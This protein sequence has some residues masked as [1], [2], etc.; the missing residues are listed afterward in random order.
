M[1]KLLTGSFRSL[2]EPIDAPGDLTI[3]NCPRLVRIAG[4]IRIQGNLTIRGCPRLETLP[5]DLEVPGTLNIRG[6]ARLSHVPQTVR[7]GEDLKI[8]GRTRLQELP[9]LSVG[10][11]VILKRSV[12]SL[13]AG[14]RVAGTLALAS[15]KLK[16]T[17]A[18]LHVGG[19]LLIRRCPELTEI[20][21]GLHVGGGLELCFSEVES[22]PEVSVKH[23]VDLEGCAQLRELPRSVKAESLNLRGCR[24]LVRLPDVLVLRQ[25]H[26]GSWPQIEWEHARPGRW[27][28]ASG[29][30]NLEN[31]ERV[32]E[33]PSVLEARVVE[34][35]GTSISR[36]PD[37]LREIPTRW[38][39]T[40]VPPQVAFNPEIL[41]AEEVFHYANVEVRR[42]LI[43]RLGVEALL[44]RLEPKVLDEDMDPGG[45][46]RLLRLDVPNEWRPWLYLECRCPSTGR[47]YHLRVPPD[48][49]SCRAA[50]AWLA[51][52]DDPDDYHPIVET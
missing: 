49:A 50:A 4:P 17:P 3:E 2:D 37:V 6:C 38:R 22:L 15:L 32:T 31:C 52:F 30:L 5:S 7:I 36:W 29:E 16:K 44:A 42:V 25:V 48:T 34:V 24:K 23:F 39:G 8:V 20:G 10:R 45:A 21:S 26:G 14:F 19:N 51:G 9:Q 28:P 13:P 1:T 43:E 46:R 18:D 27:F 33:L 35:A 11:H 40:I 41:S 47:L 12:R